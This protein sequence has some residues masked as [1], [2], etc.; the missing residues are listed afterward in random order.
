M[1]TD[2]NTLGFESCEHVQAAWLAH[3]DRND[4]PAPYELVKATSICVDQMGATQ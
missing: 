4:G 1:T 2:L 3:C